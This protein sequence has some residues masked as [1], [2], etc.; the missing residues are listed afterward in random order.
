MGEAMARGFNKLGWHWWPSDSAIATQPTKA[1][2]AAQPGP[3]PHRLRAGRQGSTDI[4]YWPMAPARGRGAAH[5]CRVREILVNDERMATG[6]V[7]FDA[8]GVEHFQA[9]RG[10][11]RGVQRRGHAA[12]AAQLDVGALSGRPGQL[13]AA[14][15]AGT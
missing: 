7:Y 12:P 9:R 11:D 5:R 13:S 15:S 14:W 8:D 10:G 3:L 6:V 1:A 4:T 2:S